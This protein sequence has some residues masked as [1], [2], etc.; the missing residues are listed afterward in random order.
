MLEKISAKVLGM[1]RQLERTQN[2]TEEIS[3]NKPILIVSCYGTDEKLVK[4]IAANEEDLLK[5]NSFKK[6]SKPVFQYVKK[7]GSSIGSKL[8]I[9]KSL[10]L[11]SKSGCTLPCNNHANCMCCVLIGGENIKEI[12]GLPISCAPGNCKSKNVI[13]LVIC[14]IC[15]KP[16]FGRTVQ[17]TQNRMSG[18]R[19]C[20]YKVLA[21]ENVDESSDDFSLGLHLVHE[22]GS[23]D[24]EDFNKSFSVQIVEN[25]S[26]SNLE[27]KEHM[28]IHKYKTLHPFG[29]NKINPFGLSLLTS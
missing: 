22:H 20:F 19:E 14:K 11:G 5:T 21:N 10:A 23:V 8:S 15:Y 17:L 1:E 27:K 9:L 25:C 18:H 6:L 29:L 16:Y 2:T 12:N 3:S 4:T 13:Y 26:P 24:R 28:Y 7:T